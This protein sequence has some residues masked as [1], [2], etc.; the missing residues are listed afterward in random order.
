MEIYHAIQR[1]LRLAGIALSL[2][3]AGSRGSIVKIE[4][5]AGVPLHAD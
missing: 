5:K 1:E 4:R 3:R 2:C